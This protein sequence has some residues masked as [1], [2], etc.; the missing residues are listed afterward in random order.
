[1][2]KDRQDE[3]A[4]HL[5]NIHITETAIDLL[6]SNNTFGN[7]HQHRQYISFQRFFDWWWSREGGL[8]LYEK[9]EVWENS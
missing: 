9:G 1:M 6:Y 2:R 4:S 5:Q 3:L 8:A 7:S